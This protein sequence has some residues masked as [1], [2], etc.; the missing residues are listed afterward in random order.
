MGRLAF[1][2]AF[3]WAQLSSPKN[4]IGLSL[5]AF[6]PT[7]ST[8]AKRRLYPTDGYA[9]PGFNIG[10]H[11]HAFI[12]PYVG[13]NLHVAQTF[14]SLEASALGKDDRLFPNAVLLS[15][16]PTISHTQLGFG[17][18]TGFQVDWM[19]LYIPLQLAMGLYAAP[20]MEGQKDRNE[21]WV[22]PK[23]SAFQL[24]LSTGLMANF[25]ITE[26]FFA[27]ISLRFTSMRSGEKEFVRSLYDRGVEERRF[28]YR[29]R[30]AVDGVEFGALV[31]IFL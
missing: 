23:F 12:A 29:E 2:G 18:G 15:K 10:V 16:T 31:G 22:Q 3:V 17:V 20:V 21:I 9:Q 8:Q 5:G 30:V 13:L 24:G 26:R 28:V 4:F 6:A 27:G 14:F 7:G 19:A 1:L 11:L 25:A